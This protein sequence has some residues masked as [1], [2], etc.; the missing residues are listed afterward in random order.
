MTTEATPS[1]ILFEEHTAISTVLDYLDR[2][3]AALERG[4]PVDA[5][6]FRD[7]DDFFT[8]FVGRCHHGKEEQ[9]LFPVLGGSPDEVALVQG[10]EKEHEYGVE[11]AAAYGAAAQEY[12]VCGLEAAAPLVATARAYAEA[13]RRHI[14]RENADLLPRA[15]RAQSPAKGR[16]L[17][18][19]F[20]RYEDEIMGVGTHERLHHMIDTLGPRLTA[21]GA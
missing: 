3:V 21:C 10:L 20:E 5:G 11:L 15:A 7:L 6:I 8:L 16:D 19:A 13:L 9:L 14:A 1:A 18:A 2:A 17:V 12:A 4:R